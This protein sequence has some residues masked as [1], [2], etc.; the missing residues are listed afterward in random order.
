MHLE[1][2]TRNNNTRN[3]ELDGL[4][5]LLLPTQLLTMFSKLKKQFEA[6][7]S[8]SVLVAADAAPASDKVKPYV[9]TH[10]HNYGYWSWSCVGL[11]C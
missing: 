4:A 5:S 3:R 1:E 2:T 10:L 6:P 11:N 7:E 8:P 9:F